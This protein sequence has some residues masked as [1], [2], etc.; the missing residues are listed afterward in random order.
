MRSNLVRTLILTVLA[1]GSCFAQK[2]SSAPTA[3]RIIIKLPDNLAPE[4]VWVRYMVD[5]RISRGE[6]MHVDGD[7]RQYV[8][9]GVRSE[10]GQPENVKVVLYSPGCE[11]K[12]YDIDMVGR[13]VEERFQCDP[14][15]TK[16][17]R[18]FIAP[19]EIPRAIYYALERRLDIAGDLEANWICTYFLQQKGGSCL[20]SSVP[21]GML[22][23]LDPADRGVFQFT[24]PDFSRDPAFKRFHEGR[25]DKIEMVLKDKNVEAPV[26]VIWPK[27]TSLGQ[28]GLN[29][30][31]DYPNEI[32]FTRAR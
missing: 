21:L 14:L 12:T 7:T 26:G 20:V 22:G 6:R 32:T 29:I 2:E 15:P 23:T 13:D 17:L 28:R 5:R 9:L 4:A 1:G 10:S 11:F 8:I 18:G 25:S 30:Q 19:S 24:V 27:D 16:V 3:P 31:A